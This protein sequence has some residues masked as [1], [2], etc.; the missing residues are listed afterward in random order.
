MA[1][2]IILE[3]AGVPA[4]VVCTDA[5]RGAADAM[6]QFRGFPGY[7][8]I[9]VPHPVEALSE[10]ELVGLSAQFVDQVIELF[11]TSHIEGKEWT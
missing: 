1:D 5:F 11:L 2:G 10:A 7:R 6:A 9:A 3:E 4:V 8:Y